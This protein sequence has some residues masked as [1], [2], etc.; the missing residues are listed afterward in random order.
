M[1]FEINQTVRAYDFPGMERKDYY[2]EGQIMQISSKE[3]PDC[4]EILCTFDSMA[5]H[6]GSRVGELIITPLKT[7]MD[8]FWEYERLVIIEE[9]TKTKD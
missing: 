6:K 2:I 5:S 7:E 1:D 8:K 4:I 9:I 3:Y